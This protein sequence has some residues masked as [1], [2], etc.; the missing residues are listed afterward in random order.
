MSW[1][2]HLSPELRNLLPSRGSRAWKEEWRD[3]LQDDTWKGSE[4][5]TLTKFVALQAFFVKERRGIVPLSAEAR[6]VFRILRSLCKASGAPY[7]FSVRL[8]YSVTSEARSWSAF[9]KQSPELALHS[10]VKTPSAYFFGAF[11]NFQRRSSPHAFGA[12]A[13]AAAAPSPPS[14]PRPVTSRIAAETPPRTSVGHDGPP[15]PPAALRLLGPPPT[16]P[17]P[18]APLVGLPPP[19]PSWMA[20]CSRSPSATDF[21]CCSLAVKPGDRFYDVL[22]DTAEA[23]AANRKDG[24]VYVHRLGRHAPVEMGFVRVDCLV[25]C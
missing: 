2:E 21:E 22:A 3:F 8:R 13:T 5:M 25:R 17:P 6:E 16:T 15:Q 4:T 19:P 23:A 9:L 7:D 14:P 12:A 24:H 10:D 11:V 18:A 1:E 20:I